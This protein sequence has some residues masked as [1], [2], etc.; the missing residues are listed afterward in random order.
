MAISN[1]ANTSA[2]AKPA[3]VIANNPELKPLAGKAPAGDAYV[4]TGDDGAKAIAAIN[5]AAALPPM[6]TDATGKAA[7]LQDGY[8]R[9][10]R[11]EL[12]TKTI[13]AEERKGTL[14][15]RTASDA[16][17]KKMDLARTLR[18]ADPGGVGEKAYFAA[19]AKP[20]AQIIEDL[21]LAPVPA[22]TVGQKAWL[23]ASKGKLQRAEAARAVVED[24]WMHGGVSFDAMGDLNDKLF[25]AQCQVDRVQNKL[26]PPK[27]G[28][29]GSAPAGNHPI[30][31]ATQGVGQILEH[32]DPVSQTVGAVALPFALMFDMLDLISRPLNALDKL[33]KK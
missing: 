30:M 5:A 14:T 13:Y 24:A 7:W 29:K 19:L 23:E 9:L 25:E 10:T 18:N 15:G 20:A 33:G 16:I 28:P 6:P 26:Y 31:G 3:R 11:A 12:A 21:K 8:A 27:P 1:V 2:P 17:F 22:N 4:S 32:Q